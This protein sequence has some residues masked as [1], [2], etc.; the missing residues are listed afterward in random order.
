MTRIVAPPQTLKVSLVCQ[1]GG[2][3]TRKNHPQPPT[4]PTPTN[5][6]YILNYLWSKKYSL[7]DDCLDEG[8]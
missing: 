2:D 3:S 7:M 6:I 1:A 4:P 5:V 8:S